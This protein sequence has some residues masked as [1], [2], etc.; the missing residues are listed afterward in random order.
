MAGQGGGVRGSGGESFT[1]KL[2]YIRPMLVPAFLA[3]TPSEW[4]ALAAREGG[5]YVW[6]GRVEANLYTARVQER[7]RGVCLMRRIR[8]TASG[9]QGRA[10]GRGGKFNGLL[11]MGG[12]GG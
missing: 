11:D 1:T 6:N 8:R 7:S 3:S 4:D 5:E 10:R 9:R 2:V 12:G